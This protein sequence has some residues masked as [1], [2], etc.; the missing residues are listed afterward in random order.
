M[1]RSFSKKKCTAELGIFKL[2]FSKVILYFNS[3]FFDKGNGMT[4]FL[5]EQK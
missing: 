4:F 2:Y 1:F 5:K 3:I